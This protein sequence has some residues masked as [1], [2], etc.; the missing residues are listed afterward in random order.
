MSGTIP[1]KNQQPITRGLAANGY[2][3]VVREDPSRRGLLFA[4]TERGVWVSFDDGEN[5]QSLQLNLPSTSMRDFE[6]YG[7][8]LIVATHGRGFWVVDDISPLR[9]IND[10]V[11]AADAH[12]FKPADAIN[13]NQGGDNG[14]PTQKDEPQAQNAPNGAALDYYLKT[15]ATGLVS[16]E[17][18]ASDGACLAMFSNDAAANARCSATAGQRGGRGRGAATEGIP[19]VSPLWRAAP[20]P[21]ATSAG[22]HRVTWS[23]SAGGGRGFG[24]R[25]AAPPGPTSGTF[26]ARLTVNGRTYTETFTI[27]PDPRNRE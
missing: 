7:N 27:K 14:T 21:L 17:V 12:L 15:A 22:M 10:T 23:P 19:N 6:I 9:Q 1:R 20:E 13:W 5:W 11:A 2:V 24:G 18:L 3:H 4:G 8:D 16:L 26:T 25:G